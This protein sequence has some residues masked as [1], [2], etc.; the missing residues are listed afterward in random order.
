MW[1]DAL[2]A[3]FD[4]DFLNERDLAGLTRV[5]A[6]ESRN[7]KAAGEGARPTHRNSITL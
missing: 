2:S 4:V 3:A 6:D 5:V 7:A 1:A